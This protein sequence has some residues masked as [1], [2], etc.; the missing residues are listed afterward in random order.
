MRRICNLC[1]VFVLSTVPGWAGDSDLARLLRYPA[2]STDKI[3]FV[4]AGDIWIVDA[5][6]GVARQLTSHP[7]E[8]LF[9]RFSP[10]GRWIAFTGE[11]SGTEQVY[12]ISVDGGTPRQLTFYNDVGELPPRGGVDNQV[13]GWTLDGKSVLF[14]AH[15]APWSDRIGRPYLVPVA[16]G[17]E[18]PLPMLSGSGC[19]YSPDGTRMAF[20]PYMRE[21]R[22]WKRYKGGQ[23]QDVWIYD[24]QKSTAE[25]ITDYPGTD[26]LPVWIGDSIYFTSDRGSIQKLNLWSYD[27]KTRETRQVTNHDR[28]DVLWPSGGPGGV[29]YDN[30]GYIWRYDPPTGKTAMVP[31][32]LFG[33]FPQ[34]LPYFKNLKEDIQNFDI[35][36]NA[37]RAL[38]EARGEIFTVPAKEGEPRNLTNTQ[39]VREIQPCW[40]PNGDW[41]A[42]L[43]D[44][45][46]E[47]EIYVRKS[48]GSGDERRVTTD[49]DI[50]R[51]QPVWSPDSRYLAYG[52]KKQ[53][54]RY[55]DVTNGKSTEIDHGVLS[56]LT[57]YNWSPDSRFIVYPKEAAT[58][59]PSIWVYSLADGKT[60]QLTSGTSSDFEPVFDPQGRYLYFLSNRDYNLTFSGFEFSYVYTQPTRIYAG[61]LARDGPALF[62]PESDEQTTS[63]AKGKDKPAAG[64]KA[65]GAEDKTRS[66]KAPPV[67]VKIDFDGFESRIRA[68]PGPSG[69]YRNLAA[70]EK[71]IFYVAGEDDKVQLKMFSLEDK[72][73]QTVLEGVGVYRLSQDGKRLLF[74]KGGD[75]GIVDAAANQKTDEA[76]LPLGKLEMKIDPKAEWAEMYV[77]AWR[78]LRDWYYDPGMN[79][80]DWKEVRE[81]YGELVPY[82]ADRHD[83]DYIFGEVAGEISSGHVYVAAAPHGG[84]KRVEGGLLGADVQPDPSGYYRVA[85][86]FPGEN[87]EKDF[88]SPLTE[89]GVAVRE[90]DLILAVD[91]TPTKG[92]D[93]FYRL[94]EGK[95]DSVVTLLVNSKPDASTAHKERVRTV[96]KETDLRYLDWV[97]ATRR[98]VDE[99]SGGRIGYIHL[100]DTAVA[101]NRELFKGFYSQSTKEA[102]I[103]DDRWN[104]GGFIPNEM[105]ELLRRPVLN[106]WATRGLE[107]VS[108]PGFAIT[109]PKVCLINGLAGSGGDAFPY[110]FRELGLG[111]LIGT[112]TWGGLIGLSG[113][114]SLLDGGAILAPTFR[115]FDT[116]GMWAVEGIG[117]APD[118]EVV[119]R[120]DLMAQGRDPSLEKGIEVLL[121]QLKKNPPKKIVVPAAPG[122]PK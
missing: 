34:T 56:D 89:P 115:F 117:V 23:A 64:E 7:G 45:T 24:L 19:S 108:T 74:Q 101:G 107:P 10:D 3:A 13:M 75:Y 46:G 100:P 52:D 85:K 31:I 78:I 21:F 114:P 35:S 39:S 26:N 32:R 57:Y 42:Y 76:M 55:V 98:R 58:R 68:I 53:R 20:T 47:Y 22:T 69:D 61:L 92:V 81:R 120:P 28:Y 30:G 11:Y 116:H 88:R 59:L 37:K 40:S 104:G 121:D 95:G 102:L 41:I 38:F 60:H 112:R 17:M 14:A 113:S 72:K 8:E 44:R 93:N 106:F 25:Q 62:P 111:Q 70:T 91:G 87:W 5:S 48:D 18:A 71:A 36:P 79:G 9:P 29:V 66:G 50:W 65:A 84:V 6:G 82:V 109:G 49:G 4:Y 27:T 86:I 77:D 90:G 54:L 118:I 1:L 83:L 67:V 15:R 94:M 105:I 99:A 122:G 110:Y 43:S 2:I 96:K 33:D 12:V 51:F 119:D 63:A 80:V 16:G 73:E 103:L 97:Q